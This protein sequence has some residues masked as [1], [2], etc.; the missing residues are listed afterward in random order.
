MGRN[1]SKQK[2]QFYIRKRKSMFFKWQ[3]INLWLTFTILYSFSNLQDTSKTIHYHLKPIKQNTKCHETQLKKKILNS[4]KYWCFIWLWA[5]EPLD[6]TFVS[7]PLQT[8]KDRN[9]FFIKSVKQEVTSTISNPTLWASLR[10][11]ALQICR[12]WF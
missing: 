6:F 2:I 8:K 1:L 7:Y 9:I 4:S 3:F 11:K 12:V 10:H 5:F